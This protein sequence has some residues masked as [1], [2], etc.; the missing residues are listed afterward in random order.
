VQEKRSVALI[1]I[2]TLREDFAAGLERLKDSGFVKFSNAVSTSS[3]TLPSHVSMFTGELPSRHLVHVSPGV[4]MGNMTQR[5]RAG[6]RD[7]ES[8]VLGLLKVSGYRLYCYTCNPL[9]T[10]RFGFEFDWNREYW[11]PIESTQLKDILASHGSTSSSWWKL[12][13]AWAVLKTGRMGLLLKLGETKA[14][15]GFNRRFNRPVGDKGSKQALSDLRKANLP[16]LF[17]VYLNLME[18]HEPYRWGEPADAT[19]V[20]MIG[21]PVRE[22]GWGRGYAKGAAAAIEEA[23]E[24]VDG[25]LKYDPMIV[26]TSDHGQ[27]LG[28]GG[29]YGHGYFLDEELL[30]VPLYVRFP[31][32]RDPLPQTGGVVS[33][34][35]I[36]TLLSWAAGQP[37]EGIGGGEA[38]AECFGPHHDLSGYLPGEAGA[39]ALRK[40]YDVKRRVFSKDGSVLYNVSGQREE[41]AKGSLSKEEEAKL[42]GVA[43]ALGEPPASPP[44]PLSSAE[45]ADLTERLS[46]LG[47][48]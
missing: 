43:E 20:S 27:L 23:L 48:M 24:A 42:V 6:L 36:H 46:K 30:R 1:V 7:S 21:R 40:M 4:H 45:E 3:W 18:A 26:V 10:P 38:V 15:R 5:S 19:R 11:P 2:D 28:E 33:L 35:Q 44:E 16:P 29:R 47:Y 22:M 25:L 17:F 13:S 34:S 14:K 39:E 9:V 41:E 8:N 31:S 32:G 12:P 37:A